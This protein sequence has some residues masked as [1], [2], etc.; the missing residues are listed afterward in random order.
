[1]HCARSFIDESPLP[2]SPMAGVFNYRLLCVHSVKRETEVARLSLNH[3]HLKRMMMILVRIS[4]VDGWST[5]PR[6]VWHLRQLP[7]WP[8]WYAAYWMDEGPNDPDLRHSRLQVLQAPRSGGNNV[9]QF[10]LILLRVLRPAILR[11]LR[12]YPPSPSS[13]SVTRQMGEGESE[14]C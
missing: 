6:V 14:Y 4:A 13:K 7:G 10:R 8:L 3:F 2:F 11:V 1:M 9:L 5:W 12:P